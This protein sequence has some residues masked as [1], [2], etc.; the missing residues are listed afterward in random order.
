MEKDSFVNSG[1]K[2]KKFRTYI[3]EQKI[4]LQSI[5]LVSLIKK[6]YLCPKI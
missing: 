6:P 5:K 2:Q 3:K 4:D 1:K